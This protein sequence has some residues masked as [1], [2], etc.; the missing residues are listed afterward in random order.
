MRLSPAPGSLRRQQG[1]VQGFPTGCTVFVHHF[2]ARFLSF[3]HWQRLPDCQRRQK[4]KRSIRIAHSSKWAS[5]L[6]LTLT[7]PKPPTL[8]SLHTSRHSQ[9][10]DSASELDLHPRQ[11]C[12]Q[13]A[14]SPVVVTGWAKG[15][16][17][18]EFSMKPRSLKAQ[19]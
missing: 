1:L 15:R 4:E 17:P 16:R 10:Q 2:L 19:G 18:Q 13:K 11:G 6:Q 5:T 14:H 7:T 8:A 9:S 3:G 12:Q